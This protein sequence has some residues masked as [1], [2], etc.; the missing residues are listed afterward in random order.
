MIRTIE[1]LIHNGT[2]ELNALIIYSKKICYINHKKYQVTDAFIEGIIETIY[3]WKNE[4]GTDNNIDSEEFTIIVKSTDG[5][6][7]FHGKGIYP[8]NYTVLKELLGDL[9]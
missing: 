6:E 5:K 7:T 2:Q 8:Y 3:L 1:I 4:Y 9:E